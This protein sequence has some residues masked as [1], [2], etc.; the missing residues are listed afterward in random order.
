[1]QPNI[2]GS[3]RQSRARLVQSASGKTEDATAKSENYADS[4]RL[5]NS[6][7]FLILFWLCDVCLFCE[8]L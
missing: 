3:R 8:L 4:V 6:N 5:E 2:G 1:M 7:G